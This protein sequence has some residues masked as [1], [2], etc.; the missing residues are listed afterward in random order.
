[1]PGDTDTRADYA[2]C[3]AYIKELPINP[4]PEVYGLHENA[5]ITKGNQETKQV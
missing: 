4:S 5:N 1:V 2:T 3:I